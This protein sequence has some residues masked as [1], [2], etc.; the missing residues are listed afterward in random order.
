MCISR[1]IARHC[2]DKVICTDHT[3][4]HVRTPVLLPCYCS[5]SSLIIPLL[6]SNGKP[7]HRNLGTITALGY[8]GASAGLVRLL[9]RR[10]QE[11]REARTIKSNPACPCTLASVQWHLRFFGNLSDCYVKCLAKK[12]CTKK[13]K[14]HTI[15][16]LISKIV[17]LHRDYGFLRK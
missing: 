3:T 16:L 11:T 17:F 2:D 6:C 13:N 14:Q 4:L 5:G 1:S 12:N 10:A 7:R 15:V 8:A 9:I